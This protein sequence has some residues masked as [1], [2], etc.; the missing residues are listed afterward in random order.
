MQRCAQPPAP[1]RRCWSCARAPWRPP[2]AA[3]W[4]NALQLP[5]TPPQSKGAR[6]PT[7]RPCPAW[8]GAASHTPRYLLHPAHRDDVLVLGHPQ[9]AGHGL[10][11]AG[12]CRR[13]ACVHRSMRRIRM[14]SRRLR[15]T[16]PNGL[17]RPARLAGRLAARCADPIARRS[18][19]VEPWAVVDKALRSGSVAQPGGLR[20]RNAARR[21]DRVCSTR[22][23]S[24][25][26]VRRSAER[27]AGDQQR[28]DTSILRLT[29]L[30]FRRSGATASSAC[31]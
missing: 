18:R 27:P 12:D 7:S 26:R 14:V 17:Q 19:Q 31:S 11:V 22:S 23:A 5:G 30:L 29:Q 25:E 24:A 28:K 2:T 6:H 10:Q 9:R 4:R 20:P 13:A 1:S 21:T 15:T 16:Q 8:S 3:A